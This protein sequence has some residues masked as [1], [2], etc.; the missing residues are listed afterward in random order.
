MRDISMFLKNFYKESVGVLLV[1]Q[2]YS[3][4]L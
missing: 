1:N 4:G 2:G 3:G